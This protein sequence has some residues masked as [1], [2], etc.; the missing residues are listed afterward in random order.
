MKTISQVTLL[1]AVLT[2][3]TLSETA[4]AQIRDAAA[5]ARGD[6]SFL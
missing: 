1:L 6:Y 2:I 4:H 3:S 5:K